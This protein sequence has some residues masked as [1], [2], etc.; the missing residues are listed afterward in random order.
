MDYEA[1]SFIVHGSI[2]SLTLQEGLEGGNDPCQEPN[3]PRTDKQT[4]NADF[5]H[6]NAN[7]GTCVPTSP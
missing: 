1:P 7:L 2:E 3:P 6:A 5:V 4:G